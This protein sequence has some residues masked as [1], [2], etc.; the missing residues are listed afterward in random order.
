MTANSNKDDSRILRK[1]PNWET[2]AFYR[3]AA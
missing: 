1:Q 2:L 3:R